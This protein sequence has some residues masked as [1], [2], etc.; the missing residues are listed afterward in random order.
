MIGIMKRSLFRIIII[1][2]LILFATNITKEIKK[3]E[4]YYL[5][6]EKDKE[7]WVGWLFE[8]VYILPDNFL[9]II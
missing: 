4:T 7:E 2:L 3:G 9:K 5:I 8:G 6:N 1:F